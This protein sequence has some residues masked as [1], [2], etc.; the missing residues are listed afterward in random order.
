M[1]FE[2]AAAECSAAGFLYSEHKVCTESTLENEAAL[3]ETL[4][5]NST[6]SKENNKE[7][8]FQNRKTTLALL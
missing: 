6:H 5:P 1:M 3:D 2:A 7:P 8:A 4:S